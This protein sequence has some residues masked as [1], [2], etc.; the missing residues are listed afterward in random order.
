MR[1]LTLRFLAN[2]CAAADLFFWQ[3]NIEQCQLENLKQSNR[4]EMFYF[5]IFVWRSCRKTRAA[6]TSLIIFPASTSVNRFWTQN[7]KVLNRPRQ[8]KKL[9]VH[10]IYS[11]LLGLHQINHRHW[12]IREQGKMTFRVHAVI[13]I[14][15]II[16]Q[17]TISFGSSKNWYS[18][19]IFLWL[20]LKPSREILAIKRSYHYGSKIA[21]LR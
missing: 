19:Q 3:I 20:H 10:K 4:Q 8:N 2:P 11:L 16:Q 12:R 6:T 9:K 5:G 21:N 17:W 1:N 7:T 14:M 13:H 15:T 18:W